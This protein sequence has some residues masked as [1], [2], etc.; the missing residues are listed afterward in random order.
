[1]KSKPKF[2]SLIAYVLLITL[3]IASCRGENRGSYDP[4]SDFEA[5]PLNGGR[6]AE[7]TRYKR[8]QDI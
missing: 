3:S 6:G 8:S 5:R 4:E 2:L 7:I 1:M